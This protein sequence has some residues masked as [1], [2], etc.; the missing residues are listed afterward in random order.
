[1][2]DKLPEGDIVYLLTVQAGS[3]WTKSELER[4]GAASGHLCDYCGGVAASMTH[5]FHCPHFK[6][7]R[8]EA[9]AEI[10]NMD[11]DLLPEMVKL[12]IA[13]AITHVSNATYWGTP[14][15]TQE[16]LTRKSTQWLIG[17]RHL[18]DNKD[19]RALQAKVNVEQCNARQLIALCKGGHGQGQHGEYPQEVSGEVPEEPNLY[20]D[21]RVKNPTNQHWAIAGF[22]LWWPK[23]S[24][25]TPNPSLHAKLEEDAQP[26]GQGSKAIVSAP[27]ARSWQPS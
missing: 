23:Q 14:L 8:I 3:G 26:C 17:G 16:P 10:G 5:L 27:L 25:V 4:I 12:G 2:R 22:G 19:A 18:P 6:Q 9:D 11:P 20:T 24:E 13:P 15:G 1:M 7:T 21:G